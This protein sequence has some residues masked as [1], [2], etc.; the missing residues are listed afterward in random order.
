MI[1]TTVDNTD[2][3]TD[4]K[5]GGSSCRSHR[6]AQV[7]LRQDGGMSC[8]RPVVVVVVVEDLGDA[9][10][11]G[12]AEHATVTVTVTRSRIAVPRRRIRRL[13]RPPGPLRRHCGLDVNSQ[14]YCLR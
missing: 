3:A 13:L 14:T 5:V 11:R 2:L 4:Q 1:W 8:D 10:W 6:P 7:L 9:V 12:G